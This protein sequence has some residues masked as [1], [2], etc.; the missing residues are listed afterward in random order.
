M[1]KIRVDLNVQKRIFFTYR[2]GFTE[3]LFEKLGDE[4]PY[5]RETVADTVKMIKALWI[6]N[7]D[8]EKQ[9]DKGSDRFD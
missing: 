9:M 7:F 3:V 5:Y 1:D 2:E 4:H 8:L 6:L